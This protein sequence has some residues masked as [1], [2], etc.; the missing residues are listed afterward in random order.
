MPM[1]TDATTV[2]WSPF[3]YLVYL[4][5]NK[6]EYRPGERDLV[7]LSH[8]LE[9]ETGEVLSSTLQVVGDAVGGEGHG[10]GGHSAMAKT[11]GWPVALGACLVLDGR[12]RDKGVL[13]PVGREVRE[14]LLPALAEL[15]V[16]MDESRLRSLG[17]EESVIT[18]RQ[19]LGQHRGGML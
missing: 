9:L 7:L 3:D 6:L 10:P 19:V 18:M 2:S 13:R 8:E 15:G 14:Q 16:C 17:K 12:V 1:K 4:L 5:A 11:V